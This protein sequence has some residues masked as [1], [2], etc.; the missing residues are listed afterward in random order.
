MKFKSVAAVGLMFMAVAITSSPAAEA[1][2]FDRSC[3][4][5]NGAFGWQSQ[6][7]WGNYNNAYQFN[8][9]GIPYGYNAFGGRGNANNLWQQ[10]QRL[11]NQSL[12]IQQR[13]TSGNLN[14]NQAARLQDRLARIQSQQTQLSG[15]LNT[16]LTNRQQQLQQLLA[17]GRLNPNQTSRVQSLL[18][19]LQNQ[20]SMFGSGGNMFVN[21]GFLG[22]LRGFLGI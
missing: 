22:G 1:R 20:Q 5:N 8:N 10:A 3:G 11:N 17:S 4:N 19:Q 14:A 6:P 12:Q 13:L 2:R 9:N 21:T 18:T 7:G 15:V 16:G